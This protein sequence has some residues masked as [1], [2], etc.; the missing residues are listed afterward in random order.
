MWEPEHQGMTAASKSCS[1]L[2]LHCREIFTSQT[3]ENLREA[4]ADREETGKMLRLEVAGY[5]S[6]HL[7]KGCGDNVGTDRL[8][9][10]A[11]SNLQR[12][13]GRGRVRP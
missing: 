3:S 5:G 7:R 12:L 11:R 10:G 6:K 1:L 4:D 8:P 13:A 9:A 2:K